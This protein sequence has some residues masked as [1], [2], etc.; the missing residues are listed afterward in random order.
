MNPLVKMFVRVGATVVALTAACVARADTFDLNYE[1]PGVENSTAT[2]SVEGVETFDNLPTGIN[3]SF[4]ADFGASGITG[5]YS[6]PNG[7][8]INNAD[9]YGGAGGT[10]KYAV[11]FQND[12]YTLTLNQSVN[13]FGYDL[14]AL[15]PGNTVTFYNNGVEVGQVTPGQVSAVTSLNSAYYGN[16]NASFK[17]EDP[18]EANVFLNIYDTTGAFN[19]IQFSESKNFGGGY[20][21]DNQTVGF[22]TKA[23]TASPV[24]EAPMRLLGAS[25]I[26]FVILTSGFLV[27]LW[28]DGKKSRAA[29]SMSSRADRPQMA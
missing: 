2:F 18:T 1:A 7:V 10:G 24:V 27:L 5:T 25:P 19:Q 3:S 13:Y 28:Q 15:D 6:G 14:T 21:S 11:A 22:F 29:V 26:A 17:G 8:Q 16:P 4:A 20:E 23:S 12:P 9:Q